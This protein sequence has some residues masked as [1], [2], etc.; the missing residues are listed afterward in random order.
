MYQA[1]EKRLFSHRL[2]DTN[3][4]FLPARAA[5]TAPVRV[6][7]V[8]QPHFSMMA[9]TAAVDALVTANLVHSTPLFTI[10]SYGL[11]SA[12]VCSDLAI[13]ISANHTLDELPLDGDNALDVVVVCGGFRCDLSEQ[14]LLSRKLR[15]AAR[16]ERVLGGLWN[17]A[18]ALAHAGTL[19]GLCCAIHPDNHSFAKERFSRVEISSRALEANSHILTSAGPSSALEMMLLLIERLHGTDTVRAIREILSSDRLAD[20]SETRLA[21]A[22]NDPALPRPLRDLLRLMNSNIEEPLS[23][24]ELASYAGLSRRRMER[25]FQTHLQATPSRYYLELRITQARRLLLQSDTSIAN[26]AVACGFVSSTHFSH[27][28][29]D[30][31]GV[32]PSQARQ[33]RRTGAHE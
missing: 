20:S 10:S 23:I 27:C 2:R 4:A 19:D 33:L 17:G 16:R 12:T 30:F 25:L 29:K 21:L 5:G 6:G 22:E 24:D 26:I 3:S 32:S 18:V 1:S 7:F 9:F 13:D 15:L 14:G 28:F 11:D 31:F 8:L